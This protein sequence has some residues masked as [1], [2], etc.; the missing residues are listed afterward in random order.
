MPI[1][2]VIYLTLGALFA[3]LGRVLLARARAMA[4][5]HTERNKK[6][7][8]AAIMA[9]GR[10]NSVRDYTASTHRPN[11]YLPRLYHRP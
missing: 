10:R 11:A 1:S 5:N 9:G 6:R 4:G 7:E 2:R 3:E 8:I